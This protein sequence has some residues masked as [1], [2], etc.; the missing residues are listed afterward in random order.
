[1]LANQ[2]LLYLISNN[3]I[4]NIRVK[5]FKNSFNAVLKQAAQ[6]SSPLYMIPYSPREFYYNKYSSPMPPPASY[7]IFH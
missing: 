2:T 5:S 7:S 6:E 3:T 4:N 1:M